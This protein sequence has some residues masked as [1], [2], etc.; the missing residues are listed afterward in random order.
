MKKPYVIVE[1]DSFTYNEAA[2]S[3]HLHFLP[4]PTFDQLEQF[5][6]ANK[7]DSDTSP[8][9]L[10]SISSKRGVGKIISAKNYVGLITMKDG[11]VIEILP[12]LY[13]KD[14]VG[15]EIE[16]KRVFLEMLKALKEIPFKHFNVASL[17]IEKN[18]VFEIFIRMFIEETY[19]LVKRGLKSA[20]MVQQD[21]EFFYK[22]KLLVSQHIIA[23]IAHKE[24]FFIEYDVFNINRAENKLVKATLEFLR[25]LTSST[26][27]QREL[28]TL[29]TAFEAVDPSINY[30]VDFGKI[31]SN[32]NMKEYENILKWCRVFLLNKSFT[33]FSGSQVAYALLFPMEKIFESYIA[34][35]LNQG[36]D[37]TYYQMKTQDRMYHL[38]DEPERRFLLKPDI[39]VQHEHSTIVLDTKWKLLS[40]T[41]SNYGISQADMYQMYAYNK[42]YNSQLVILLYPWN[43]RVKD[44]TKP[45]TYHSKDK[46][47]VLIL[48]VNLLDIKES[49]QKIIMQINEC[50]RI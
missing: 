35:K 18:S 42:K 22:G 44:L 38:F 32:R 12:K 20:Y 43:Q 34:V 17:H 10:M 19:T 49:I 27:S 48:F 24:R 2:Q 21:N 11:T 7:Q 47:T 4:Q 5:I 37:K 3:E 25:K 8:L 14:N 23:N 50:M 45:I 28:R 41:N 26:T 29:L 30:E 39:V 6:L 1:Y 40:M 13:N 33:T 15:S 36:L 16:I 31:I 46:V 9:E